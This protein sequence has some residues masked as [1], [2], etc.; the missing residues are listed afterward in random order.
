MLESF[1]Y[2]EKTKK[3]VRK[4]SWE[5]EHADGTIEHHYTEINETYR[6]ERYTRL[7]NKRY[8]DAIKDISKSAILAFAH[9][10]LICNRGTNIAAITYGELEKILDVS[11]TSVNSI[12]QELQRADLIRMVRRGLWMVNPMISS[13]CYNATHKRLIGEYAALQTYKEKQEQKRKKEK[14]NV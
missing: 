10:M 2:D 7:F 1:V 13:G 14:S 9:M 8:V 11:N 4:L 6:D 12:M 5:E 3:A